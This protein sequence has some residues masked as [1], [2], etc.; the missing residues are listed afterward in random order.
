MSITA[1]Y[2]TPTKALIS[3]TIDT[4]EI[5]EL[6]YSLDDGENWLEIESEVS[7]TQSETRLELVMNI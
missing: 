2:L 4:G 5:V 6:S 3:Y 1:V 7:R